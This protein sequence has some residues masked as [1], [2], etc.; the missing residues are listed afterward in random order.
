MFLKDEEEKGKE[1]HHPISRKLIRGGLDVFTIV[2]HRIVDIM[3][4]KDTCS[5]MLGM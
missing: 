1:S 5:K 3:T 4:E 2:C